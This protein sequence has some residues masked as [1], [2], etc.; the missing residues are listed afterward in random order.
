MLLK[1][2][3]AGIHAGQ[4][5][6]VIPRHAVRQRP[7]PARVRVRREGNNAEMAMTLLY[8]VVG[9][10]THGA[11]V[12]HRHAAELRKLKIERHHRQIAGQGLL[13]NG[14]AVMRGVENIPVH[15]GSER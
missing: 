10:I 4:H 5:E 6:L 9:D 11:C 1:R 8:Q 7:H 13:N 12:I 2:V 3:A 15:Q 14:G